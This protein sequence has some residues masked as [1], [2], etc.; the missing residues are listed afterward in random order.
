MKVIGHGKAQEVIVILTKL[1]YATLVSLAEATGTCSEL[2]FGK[3]DED[4]RTYCRR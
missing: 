3:W 2:R 1:E 4:C